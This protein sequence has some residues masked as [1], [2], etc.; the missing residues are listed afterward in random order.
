M[1]KNN[2]NVEQ[3]SKKNGKGSKNKLEN[4][5]NKITKI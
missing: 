3:Q 5:I 4:K 2:S 1:R